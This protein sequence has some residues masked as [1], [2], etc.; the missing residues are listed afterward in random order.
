MLI[1]INAYIRH[2]R[3]NIMLHTELYEIHLQRHD[4]QHKRTHAHDTYDVGK[5]DIF[6]Q[7]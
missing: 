4:E 3:L 5:L 2:M 7:K 6:S 1:H